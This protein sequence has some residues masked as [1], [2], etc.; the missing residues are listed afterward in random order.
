MTAHTTRL[1]PGPGEYHTATCGCGWTETGWLDAVQEASLSH[2]LDPP[3]QTVARTQR[4][5]EP[6]RAPASVP[7]EA[8][9]ASEGPLLSA[10]ARLSREWDEAQE[11]FEE[12]RRQLI[13]GAM[14]AGLPREQVARAAGVSVR[15]LYQVRD[16]V[17]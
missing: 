10:L 12:Q 3:A 2:E 7:Q 5:E 9:E 4:A 8:H 15:R 14:A 16:E 11:R 17:R 1:E 6:A 13:V